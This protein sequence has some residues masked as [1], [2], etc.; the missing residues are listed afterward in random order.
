MHSNKIVAQCASAVKVFITSRNDSRVFALVPDTQRI[1]VNSSDSRSDMGIFVHNRLDCVVQS[2]RLLNGDVSESLRED[3]NHA[4]L[5]GAI[6]MFLWATLQTENICRLSTS[7]KVPIIP[8]YV[9]P[10]EEIT[11]LQSSF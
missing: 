10:C 2:K 9:L 6:E 7:S 5:N 8:L 11:C 4:L 3:L 1:C